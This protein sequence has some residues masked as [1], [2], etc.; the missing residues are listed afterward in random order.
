[1]R[2]TVSLFSALGAGRQSSSSLANVD[3]RMCHITSPITRDSYLHLLLVLH[4]HKRLIVLL[5]TY[6]ILRV[7]AT[8][9]ARDTFLH[10]LHI[11]FTFFCWQRL[12][13][14]SEF[15]HDHDATNSIYRLSTQ[16]G[17]TYL[18]EEEVDSKGGQTSCQFDVLDFGVQLCQSLQLFV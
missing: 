11:S 3:S 12:G 7:F 8:T 2:R 5:H 4:P 15:G 13:L 14:P 16:A 1:M 9:A 10:F 6:Y 18:D 17:W